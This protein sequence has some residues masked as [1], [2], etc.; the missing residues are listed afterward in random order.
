MWTVSPVKVVWA[1]F[2]RE[3]FNL[4]GYISD[5]VCFF[6]LIYNRYPLGEGDPIQCRVVN[7]YS[8]HIKLAAENSVLL[9]SPCMLEDL[10][11]KLNP[12][13]RNKQITIT[14][15]LIRIV[16]LKQFDVRITTIVSSMK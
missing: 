11:I 3:L 9:E 5:Q 1:L 2:C 14:T 15:H 4:S 12:T 7:A 8:S 6:G 16:K 13:N 10:K